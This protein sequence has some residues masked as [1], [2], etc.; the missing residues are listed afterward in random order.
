MQLAC[1]KQDVK[2]HSE[3]K[4]SSEPAERKMG[5][6]SLSSKSRSLRDGKSNPSYGFYLTRIRGEIKISVHIQ[7]GLSVQKST[8]NN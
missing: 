3:G 2:L 1:P 7:K 5:K 8:M 6:Q 4:N